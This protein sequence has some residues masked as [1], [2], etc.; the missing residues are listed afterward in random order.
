MRR[1]KPEEDVIPCSRCGG[2]GWIEV[3]GVYADTLA[4]LRL[5]EEEVTA[6]QLAAKDGCN[7]TA[8]NNRLTA[9][10]GYGLAISR[11]YGRARLFKAAPAKV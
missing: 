10:E 2:K 11:R 6:P 9:L 8:M 5:Q 1:K 3:T 4:L 7:A